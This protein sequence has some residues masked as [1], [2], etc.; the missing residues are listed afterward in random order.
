MNYN[1]VVS[2]STDFESLPGGLKLPIRQSNTVYLR[3]SFSATW[4]PACARGFTKQNNEL[5]QGLILS[6]KSDLSPLQS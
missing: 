3:T 4:D 1:A 6:M 2:I 5:S